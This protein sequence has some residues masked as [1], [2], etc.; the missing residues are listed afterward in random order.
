[1]EASMNRGLV[2]YVANEWLVL[3]SMGNFMWLN[4]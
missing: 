3:G 2:G 4:M 1:M